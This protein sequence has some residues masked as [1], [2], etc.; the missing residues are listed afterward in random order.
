MWRLR[1]LASRILFAVV[2][3]LIATVVVGGLLDV[4]L[5]RRTF[6]KQYEDRAVAV[7]NVVA[8]IPEIRTAVAA[9][10]PN[11]VIQALA[12]R[13]ADGSGASY[14]VVTD[15][16]GLRFSHPN[17]QQ[18]GLRLEEPVAVLDG[19]DH[20]GIDHGSLGRSANGKAPIFSATGAV[21]GQVSVGIVEARVAQ[22]VDQQIVAIALY[23]GIALAVGVLVALLMARALKRATFGLEPAEIASLLQDREAMLYGIREGVIGFDAKGRV[24]IVND[25][26]RRLLSLPGTIVGEALDEV[27]PP[28]R[29][30]DVLDGTSAGADQSVLTD[31]SLLVVNR[32]PVVVGGRDVGSVVT[33]RDRTEL[34]ALM[35]ELHSVTGLA[36][37]LR[38]QEHEFT[39]RLHVIAGLIDLGEF[40]EAIRFVTSEAHDHLTSAEDLRAHVTPPVVAALLLAK[41]AVAAEREIDVVITPTSHLEVPDGDAQ[42]IMTVIGNLIDNAMDA[43]AAQPPPRTVTVDLHDEDEIRIVVSDNGPGVA[44]EAADAIFIDGFS[45]KAPRGHSRRGLGLALVQRLVHRAGGTVTMTSPG[46][47]IFEVRLPL[48]GQPPIG[49]APA[50]AHGRRP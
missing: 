27:F 7:A 48:P 33:L 17:P 21:I 10:D 42:N 25:E 5:T 15:R 36:N 49:R 24:T 37:A 11:H 31:D 22:A 3:I 4:Q 1:T 40:D 38:A 14:V 19:R 34:E 47:A 30:R 9:G 41:L 50:A 28:G 32:Q 35:R 18:I 46:G 26:A 2:G 44:T 16:S 20:V 23:S 43:V 6:D 29:L 8:E 12:T 13:I 39:N 45:T